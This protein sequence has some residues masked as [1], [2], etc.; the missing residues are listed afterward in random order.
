MGVIFIEEDDVGESEMKNIK[1]VVRNDSI[2][3]NTE[4]L[5]EES[6]VWPM[7]GL[8]VGSFIQLISMDQQT[9]ILEVYN[10]INKK[11]AFYFIEGSLYNAICGDL[12][13]EEAAMEMISW[14]KVRININNDLNTNDVVRK[15]KKGLMSL[16]MESSRRKDESEWDH[17][18]K[19]SE[20]ID[21]NDENESNTIIV[22]DDEKKKT[23]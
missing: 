4:E 12:E 19:M 8:S 5:M 7:A 15:I 1:L 17:L 22:Q 2:S 9:C 11:G 18:T 20:E 3:E 6:Q 13:G 14:E 23:A 10:S 16:L 21:K